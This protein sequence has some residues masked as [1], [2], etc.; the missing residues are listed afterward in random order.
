MV[1]NVRE[2]GEHSGYFW[3]LIDLSYPSHPPPRLT[4]T[5]IGFKKGMAFNI[6][7]LPIFFYLSLLFHRTYKYIF[8]DNSTDFFFS[9]PFVETTPWIILWR[10][11]FWV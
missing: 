3:E 2:D 11:G 4:H 5:H 9:I 10:G 7:P 8:T 6:P 1:G